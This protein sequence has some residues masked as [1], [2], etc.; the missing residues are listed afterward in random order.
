MLQLN[1]VLMYSGFKSLLFVLKSLHGSIERQILKR[2]FHPKMNIM[3]FAKPHVTSTNQNIIR[4]VHMILF[5][6]SSVAVLH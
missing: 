2:M 4:V 3:L 5:S 6:K 1:K